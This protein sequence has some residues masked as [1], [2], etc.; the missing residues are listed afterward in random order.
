MS[1]TNQIHYDVIIVG[2]GISGIGIAR[3]LKKQL[4][5]VTFLIL[6]SR[7]EIGGTWDQFR[8]PGVR[9]DSDMFTMSYADKPWQ[10]DSDIVSPGSSI[11]DYLVDAANDVHLEEHI[12]FNHNVVSANWFSAHSE[13]Q[14]CAL[15]KIKESS[16]TINGKF[17]VLASGY[18][19]YGKAVEPE[20]PGLKNFLGPIVSPQFWPAHLNWKGKKISIVGSGATAVTLLPALA[21]DA[22]HVTL[23]QRSP[24]YIFAW[25]QLDSVAKLIKSIFTAKIAHT[26]VRWKNILFQ[27]FIYKI[28]KK[29]PRP[30]KRL[31][32]ARTRRSL[33]LKLANS[34][35]FIPEYNPWDQRLCLAP[36]GDFFRALNQGRASVET[37][38]IER[39][40]ENGIQLK[41]G[42]FVAAEILVTA[43]GLDI[44]P[45]GNI[46]LCKDH[47]P[48]QPSETIGY[49]GVM[50][51]D[52]PNFFFSFG[53]INASWTLKVDLLGQYLCRVLNHKN[54]NGWN[55]CTP[56]LRQEDKD[57]NI[58]PM[59]NSF[60]PGYIKRKIHLFPKQ[61]N[62]D[63]WINTQD[64]LADRKLLLKD[65]IDDDVLTFR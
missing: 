37:S 17:L 55:S 14:I 53:Y 2:A 35:N 8:Y 13:W 16:K 12:L 5:K 25:P 56:Q 36:N 7:S 60:S 18:F 52:I 11:L 49:K 50:L 32:I 30:V 4:P 61:G 43:T 58:S 51:A 48:F 46:S 20:I 65:P 1:P 39:V 27:I 9:S 47:Q 24:T 28:A 54:Q 22:D 57:M 38:T 44:L 41:S 19:N 23:I 33:N 15:D 29:Y 10:G 34:T 40:V 3:A 64:Y 21:K 26:L 42:K 45:M 6:E 63:P 59:I 31:L 62:R